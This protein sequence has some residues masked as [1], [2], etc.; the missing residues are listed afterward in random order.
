M[1]TPSIP[2]GAYRYSQEFLCNASSHISVMT[3]TG[4][5]LT[6]GA[7]QVADTCYAEIAAN[8]S[9]GSLDDDWAIGPGHS[10]I[11]DSG[12]LLEGIHDVITNGTS[13]RNSIP[14]GAAAIMRKRTGQVGRKFRGRCWLPAGYISEASVDEAGTIDS[15]L[16]SDLTDQWQTLIGALDAFDVPM[17]VIGPDATPGDFHETPVTT[18]DVAPKIHWLRRRAR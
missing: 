4:Y 7:Q 11:N 9:A 18:G 13:D 15:S 10:M 8:F 16:V 5:F 17:T 3:W 14:I 6:N 2:P 12:V 1:P